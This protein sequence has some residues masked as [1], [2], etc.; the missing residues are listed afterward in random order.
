MDHF[1]RITD[2]VEF[3]LGHKTKLLCGFF[4][5]EVLVHRIVCDQP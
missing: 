2:A 4:E 5:R 3:G 1:G